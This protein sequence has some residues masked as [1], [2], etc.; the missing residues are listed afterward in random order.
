MNSR[1]NCRT[2]GRQT[3]DTRIPNCS[4]CQD[5]WQDKPNS[6]TNFKTARLQMHKGRRNIVSCV[7]IRPL[8]QLLWRMPVVF[9]SSSGQ[10]WRRQT[11]A[12]PTNTNLAI[13]AHFFCH[14]CLHDLGLSFALQETSQSPTRKITQYSTCAALSTV[15]RIRI[16]KRRM[17]LHVL[18]RGT[19]CGCEWSVSLSGLLISRAIVPEVIE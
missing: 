3:R 17:S 13:L 8:N 9:L 5:A 7:R 2:A 11:L 1:S 16:W 18:N 19:R 4:L 14:S 6:Y 15:T 12:N 10:T